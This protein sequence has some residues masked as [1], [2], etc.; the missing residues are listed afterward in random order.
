[1]EQR[2]F[3][4]LISPPGNAVKNHTVA[5]MEDS[6]GYKCHLAAW[7]SLSRLFLQAPVL[8]RAL[9]TEKSQGNDVGSEVL[10]GKDPFGKRATMKPLVPIT[11]QTVY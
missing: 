5:M 4:Q 6:G 3:P 11:A 7:E 10:R 1:M 9:A 2:L 8:E